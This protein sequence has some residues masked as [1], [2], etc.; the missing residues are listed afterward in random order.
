VKNF[1]LAILFALLVVLTTVTVRRSVGGFALDN[2][3]AAP[4]GMI[5]IG[6]S[7][8][9][10]PP[11]GGNNPHIGTS[12]APLPPM[13]GGH[14]IGTSPAPLPPMG[15]GHKI[16]TS[17]APLPPMGGN[18]PH[19]GTSPAPLPPMGGNNPHFLPIS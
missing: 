17:P 16:G 15:G 19:I 7:P 9:P 18:N 4:L 11:M 1:N 3:S 2:S 6:T 5:A 14:K 13:G 10:L 8:A 12:P